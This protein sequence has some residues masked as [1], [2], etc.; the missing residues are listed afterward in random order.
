MAQHC[1]D[2]EIPCLCKSEG[3][4]GKESS[5]NLMKRAVCLTGLNRKESLY[6]Q[7]QL[8]DVFLVS[9]KC[10]LYLAK[11][12]TRASCVRSRITSCSTSFTPSISA[13]A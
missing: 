8:N 10:A 5:L 12:K 1:G 11:K 7:I 2:L 9:S 13:E 3:Y 6:V 4:G